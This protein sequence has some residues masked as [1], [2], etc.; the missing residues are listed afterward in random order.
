MRPYRA[1]RVTECFE[2]KNDVNYMLWPLQS[3]DLNSTKHLWEILD[4]PFHP[5]V[6]PLFPCPHHLRLS[7][8]LPDQLPSFS[9]SSSPSSQSF[10]RR[11]RWHHI[12]GRP[13]LPTR[14]AGRGTSQQPS[15]TTGSSGCKHSSLPSGDEE[16]WKR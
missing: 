3:L 9:S 4:C 8:P 10:L 12:A 2:Y 13:A 6:S 1:N 5:S 16:S 7:L 14:P 11:G 15:G